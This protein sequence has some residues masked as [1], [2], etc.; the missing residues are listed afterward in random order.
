MSWRW[1]ITKQGY[2]VSEFAK[3]LGLYPQ[4]VYKWLNGDNKPNYENANKVE[5]AL[6]NLEN[7]E[8]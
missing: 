4:H 7:S 5:T 3:A 1:R 6:I 2:N 8:L